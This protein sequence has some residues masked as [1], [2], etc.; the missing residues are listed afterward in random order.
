M[1]NVHKVKFVHGRDANQALVK[2]LVFNFLVYGKLETTVTKAKVLKSRLDSLI[3]RVKN[4]KNLNKKVMYKNLNTLLMNKLRETA[5]GLDN[6]VGGY[7]RMVKT[8]TR[9]GDGAQ[10][11]RIEWTIAPITK[12]VP[13]TESKSEIVKAEKT[14]AVDGKKVEK[15]ATKK[16]PAVKKTNVT[17]KV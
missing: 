4:D 1:K 15:K 3:Y 2:K 17:K 12:N 16:N 9:V 14:I 7:V 10:M 5:D 11:A 8:G 13:A 6:R